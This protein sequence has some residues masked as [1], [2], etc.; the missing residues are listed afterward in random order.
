MRVL[1]IVSLDILVDSLDCARRDY[2]TDSAI[3]TQE[4]HTYIQPITGFYEK[5][6]FFVLM[7][8][9]PDRRAKLVKLHE[10]AANQQFL[11]KQKFAPQIKAAEAVDE[12]LSEWT[13]DSEEEDTGGSDDDVEESLRERD[14][15]HEEAHEVLDRARD[16]LPG[17]RWISIQVSLEAG[18]GGLPL[19]LA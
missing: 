2:D 1:S 5:A 4:N 13:D 6:L 18:R 3:M 19:F 16:L 9:Y 10:D 7:E 17:W 8:F 12:S 11:L 14:R 15:L